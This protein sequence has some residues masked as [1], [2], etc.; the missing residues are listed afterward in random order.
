MKS[1]L[2]LIIMVLTLITDPA[3][4]GNIVNQ[5]GQTASSLDADSTTDR[6][7]SAT[8]R[9]DTAEDDGFEADI[10]HEDQSDQSTHAIIADP[11]EGFNRAVFVFNDKIYMYGLRPIAKGYAR[12]VPPFARKGVKNFFN[13]LLFPIR[14]VNN[15]LQGKAESAATEFSAFF[16]NTTLGFGGLNDFARKYVGIRLQ[17]EDFGQTLGSYGIGNGIYL[18]L[19]VLGPSSLRDAL[20]RA[21]DRLIDPISYAQP[22]EL[23]WGASGLEKINGTSFHIGEYEAF[24]EAAIDPYTAMRNAYIQNRN[25]LVNDLADVQKLN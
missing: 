1:Y 17:D 25:A 5:T 20:G 11:L 12:V 19:P 15:L 3:V 14:F 6:T 10:F 13:N 4:A 23:S 16:I 21:G 9:A 2:V 22:W 7:I 24:K 8:D 18:M